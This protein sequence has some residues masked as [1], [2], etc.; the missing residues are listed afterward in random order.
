MKKLI[1]LLV[2]AAGLPLF[3][4]PNLSEL[5]AKADQYRGKFDAV[6]L[7]SDTSVK[8]APS[9]MTH[10]V[11]ITAVKVLN[12]AGC[13]HY[14]TVSFFYD[15]L[16]QIRQVLSAEVVH[17][18]GSKSKIP[19]NA[20]KTYPQPERWIYWPN[21]RISIPF[22][23]LKPGDIVRYKVEMKGFSYALLDKPVRDSDSRF[24]PPM[25]GQ[26]YAIV[27]FQGFSP[28]L[29][30]SYSV[31][32]PKNKPIQF[33]FYNGEVTPAAAFTKD[34]MKYTFTK[35]NIEPV[36]RE[37]HMVDISNVCQKL[38][39]STTVSW[40]DKSEWFYGVNEHFA[41]NYTPEIKKKVDEITA[42]CK[43][44]E[45]KIDKL[46]HWVAHYIRYSG[47][48]MGKGEGYTLHPAAMNYRDRQGV[49]KDKASM[50]ISFLR[51]AGFH[52]YPAMTMAGARIEDFPADHFNH[53]VVAL[54]EKDGSFRMLDPTW[55]PWVREEWSSAE[56]EQQYL[57][58]Y[59]DGQ[60][61]R[62]TP[63]S[64]PEKHYYRLV[65]KCRID[66]NGTLTGTLTL[67]AEGQTDARIRRYAQ[68]LFKNERDG[69][70]IGIIRQAFPGA[71]IKKLRYQNP[72]D[73]SKNMT[74]TISFKIPHFA[75]VKG[76]TFYFRSPALM[77]ALNDPA[78]RMLRWKFTDKKKREYGF[79]SS[80]TKLF[81][82]REDIRFPGTLDTTRSRLP[83]K[84]DKI[85][86]KFAELNL[87]INPAQNTVKT[88][89]VL[90]LKK[91][92]YPAAAWENVSK[93]VGGFQ[94]TADTWLK[95]AVTGGAK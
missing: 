73:I 72:W 55:V 76:N 32:L 10:T 5:S 75:T 62:T 57:V 43:T 80:C 39:I 92:V 24:Q 38:L 2:I 22:G 23:L 58:G 48:S 16:T 53:C 42:N 50:L 1:F 79:R 68:R 28:I 33:K 56:Q 44:D 30:K 61:L 3:A 90:S 4:L 66:R 47:L 15:P 12:D 71:V 82:I 36:K 35:K 6:T 9:G 87:S 74:A 13:R 11:E 37:P 27:H 51:A 67:S 40:K 54:R 94:K 78:N 26:F 83:E 60:P 81:D 77:Y 95:V 18:D 29:Y 41:F 65:S 69:Y 70:F 17:E 91:R 86:G 20:V 25:K 84:P 31:E 63:F 88:S 93:A 45:E 49:C 14:Q 59:K 85:T 89:A 19:L 7:I 21:T 64:P 52:A 8:V 34:G 46:N